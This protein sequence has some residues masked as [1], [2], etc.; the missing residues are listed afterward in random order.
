MKQTALIVLLCTAWCVAASEKNQEKKRLSESLNDDDN[1]S[2]YNRQDRPSPTV[3][4]LEKVKDPKSKWKQE[5]RKHPKNHSR[6]LH[7]TK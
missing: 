7:N 2:W 6:W 3:H 5:Q 4:D 1:P